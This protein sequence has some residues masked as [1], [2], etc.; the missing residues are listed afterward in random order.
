MLQG[1]VEEQEGQRAVHASRVDEAT[2]AV[3]GSQA[4]VRGQVR[5]LY[6]LHRQGLA[7]V[8]FG[9]VDAR[10]LRRRARYLSDL[11]R[12]DLV[13][14]RAFRATVVERE[15][16]RAAVEADLAQL[17]ALK[18]ELEAKDA[19]A[20]AQRDQRME[21]LER[22][23]SRR[24]LALR[25]LAE[26][27]LARSTLDLTLGAQAWGMGSAPEWSSGSPQAPAA[28]QAWQSFRDAYG[29]LP[30]PVHG[31]LAQRF[32]PGT[33]PITGERTLHTGLQIAAD[34]GEPVRAIFRGQVVMAGYVNGFGQ[35]VAVRHDSYTTVYA[36]LGSVA[37]RAE[38]PVEQGQ[39]LGFVGDSGLGAGEGFGLG[40]ELRYNNSPQDPLPWLIREAG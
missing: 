27:G 33:D 34:Q 14:L 21:L 23:R 3:Q 38:Q 1:R 32:G 30:W 36:H 25:V 28:P 4:L 16:A 6:R 8:L 5:A 11:V 22:V 37:V 12:A 31:R 26:Y 24:E 35:T 9:A 17:D 13:K 10:G 20:R 19:E 15:Q 18:R 7:Q 2:R 29:Q 39:V 40:F